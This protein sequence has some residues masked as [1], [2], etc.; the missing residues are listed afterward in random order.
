MAKAND[1]FLMLISLIFLD[2][3]FDNYDLNDFLVSNMRDPVSRLEGVD[4]VQIFGSLSSIYV[5]S[6]KAS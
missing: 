1:T 2:G 4:S 6:R 5:R 3:S